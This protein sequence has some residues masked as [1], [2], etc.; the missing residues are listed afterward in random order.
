[1]EKNGIKKGYNYDN[2]VVYELKD[3]KGLVKEYDNGPLKFIGEYKDGERNGKGR[4]YNCGYLIFEGEY[5]KGKRWNG[6]G[7][8]KDKKVAYELKKG[9]E[10][11]KEYNIIN[12]CLYFEAEYINGERNGKCKLYD[13]QGKLQFEGEFRNEM[14]NGKG[15]EYDFL[16]HYLPFEGEYLY[17]QKRMGKEYYTN[18]IVKFEGE[19]LYDKPW[20]GKGYD[21]KGKL[22]YKLINGNGKI[23]EF[24]DEGRIE[25][26]GEYKN[27]KRNGKGKE[28]DN[29]GRIKYEGEYVNGYWNGKGKE[30]YIN[31]NVIFEGEYLEGKKWTGKGYD[32]N[33]NLIYEIKSGA[34]LIK[35]FEETGKLITFEGEYKNGERNGKGKEY[36]KGEL[37]FDGE[38][39]DGKRWN[40]KGK[41]Y[42]DYNNEDLNFEGEYLNGKRWN[43]E[44]YDSDNLDE[45][46]YSNGKKEK[47]KY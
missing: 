14:K 34:G 37:L 44:G 32:I 25:Y 28:Y 6:K 3:G 24:D 39:L 35:E 8:N 23:K 15:K 12:N 7:Y 5:W 45:V 10:I 30:Y 47:L 27:G 19:L 17:D 13:V 21:L 46:Q 26:I 41:E 38:F 16:G 4:E 18:G 36:N 1:M 9:K 33:K 11:V 20:N 2:E 29:N 40:G 43:G 22:I 31:G 42:A